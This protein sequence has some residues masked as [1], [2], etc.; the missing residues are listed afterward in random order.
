MTKLETLKNRLQNYLD[1]EAAVL[2]GQEYQLGS[3]RLRRADLSSIRQA[4][5]DLQDDIA[6]EEAVGGRTRRVV[7]ID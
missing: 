6:A 4:I 7:F 2:R 3:R 1:A 5:C